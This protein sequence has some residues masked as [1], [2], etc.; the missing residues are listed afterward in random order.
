M[1]EVVDKNSEKCKIIIRRKNMLDNKGFDLWANNY[2]K[3]VVTSDNENTYPFA[4]YKKL[5]NT[6]LNILL[7]NKKPTVLDIGIGTGVI[8][9]E[10]HKHG[11]YI[12]GIDFS[13]E[14][15]KIS[16]EKMPSAKLIQYDFTKG[17]PEGISDEKFDYIIST[18]AMHHLND[19]D[20]I[21]F[22]EGL[23]EI[24]NKDGSIVIG[25]V[26]FQTKK[27]LEEC[28]MQHVDEW[29]DDEYYFVYDEIVDKISKEFKIQYNQISFCAGII[30]I[31]KK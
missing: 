22:I 11:F 14:M 16:K 23:L 10:L 18:Y 8:C 3:S 21:K 24:L 9:T 30:K 29:D 17:L 20:K 26:G 27:K 13:E 6:V 31:D 4:G 19:A 2:D 12:T 25:D 1:I 5:M 7:N 15:I 28:K